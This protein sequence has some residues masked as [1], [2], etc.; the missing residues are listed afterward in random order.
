MSGWE[1]YRAVYGAELRAA[2]REFV[3]HGWPVVEQSETALLLVTGRVVDVLEV[4]AARG[5]GICAALRDVGAVV[6]V[7]A[8]P[9]GSWW[10]PVIAG[11]EL[12]AELAVAEGVV[13]HAAGDAVLAPPSEVPDG[14]V[15]WRVAPALCGYQAAPADLIFHAALDAG[16]ALAGAA[17]RPGAQRPAGV[18][19]AGMR[20]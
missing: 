16:H 1:S 19:V 11:A 17:S 7:A 15:H 12:P 13:W 4:P 10:Y 2:A 8:T 3:D 9:T 5:R 18:T 20:S 14:W 6:P